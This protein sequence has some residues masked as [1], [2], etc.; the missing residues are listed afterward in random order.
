MITVNDIKF[1]YS[2]PA[3]SEGLDTAQADPDDSI[4]GFISST[5]WDGGV[6]NDVFDD[7]TPEEN[8]AGLT[9][10]RCVFIRNSSAA[11]SWLDVKIWLEQV[12]GGS[13]IAIGLD[14]T[15]V[16]AEDSA[17]AQTVSVIDDV[18]APPGVVFSAPTSG[19]PISIGNMGPGTCQAIWIRRSTSLVSPVSG[20]GFTI[21]SK[22]TVL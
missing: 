19:S 5:E 10:Y 11:D 20:D 12:A 7:V 17:S 8:A 22:G 15:G 9:D 16:V 4:G 2:A 18:S 1:H 6:K 21:R 3:G 13:G 14:P